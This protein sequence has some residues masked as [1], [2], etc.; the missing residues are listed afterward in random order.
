[1]GKMRVKSLKVS[2]EPPFSRTKGPRGQDLIF[3]VYKKLLSRGQWS[4]SSVE[5]HVQQELIRK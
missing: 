4:V 3:S 1:M 5:P 2:T